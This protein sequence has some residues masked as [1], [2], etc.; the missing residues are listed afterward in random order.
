MLKVVIHKSSLF[1]SVIEK[2]HRFGIDIAILCISPKGLSMVV[3]DGNHIA[4]D[5]IFWQKVVITLAVP[6]LVCQR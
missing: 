6:N 4:P 1:L 5:S 2:L 3:G